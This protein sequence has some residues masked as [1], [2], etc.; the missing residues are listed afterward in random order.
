MSRISIDRLAIAAL[1]AAALFP[2][3]AQAGV[4][5]GVDAWQARDY[6][7]AIAE[8]R[9]PSAAGDPDAQFNLAQAYKLGRGVPVDM[10]M[11]QSLYEKAAAQGHEQ[12]QANLGLILFQNGDRKAA[13]PWIQKAANRGEPRAQ[14]VLGTAHFNGDLAPRDWPRAY[15][16]MTRAA[17]AGLPQ[18]SRSL[19]EMDKYIPIGQRQQGVAIARDFASAEPGAGPDDVR[20]ATTAGAPPAIRNVPLP[21]GTPPRT[22]TADATPAPRPVRPRVAAAAPPPRPPVPP[23][24]VPAAPPPPR[25]A[26][27]ARPPVPARPAPVPAGG[28]AGGWRVQLG[29][30]GTPAAAQAAWASMRAAPGLAGLRPMLTKAGAVV[31]LQAGSL[32]SRAAAASAC[33]GAARVAKGCFPVAP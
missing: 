29:A 19:S 32:P 28:G 31:R 23:R 4:K 14:Y 2:V 7:K 33:A 5:E 30:F 17:A 20:V 3:A 8:W 24:A 12:A 16:L 22:M 9:G 6:A 15:A 26:V 21:G 27:A 13:M 1:I 11:A 10:K 25:V 18:A